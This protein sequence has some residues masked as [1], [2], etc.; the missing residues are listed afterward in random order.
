MNVARPINQECTHEWLTIET[1]STPKRA[2][3]TCRGLSFVGCVQWFL[4]HILLCGYPLNSCWLNLWSCIKCQQAR[5]SLGLEIGL[6]YSQTGTDLIHVTAVC[7]GS[8]LSKGLLP[9]SL[10]NILTLFSLWPNV[11]AP[12]FI[13]RQSVW[14]QTIIY[15]HPR[16][17]LTKMWPAHLLCAT[18]APS[19]CRPA[20]V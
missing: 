4:W 5:S 1:G 15:Q 13:Y 6:A 7:S 10:C 2:S 12:T 14:A 19:L 9:W 3:E 20:T 18:K 11:L 8:T 17:V 16:H